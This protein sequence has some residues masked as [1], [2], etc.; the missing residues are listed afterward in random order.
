M[1]LHAWIRALPFVGA[2]LV[3]AGS[4]RI[5]FAQ[6]NGT[7][8]IA[9]ASAQPVTAAEAPAPKQRIAVATRT[10]PRGTVLSA[11]DF[12]L[13]DTTMRMSATRPHPTPVVAGWVPRRT[14]TAGEILREPAV[15]APS[16]VN[17]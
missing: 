11:G 17:A 3:G 12:E 4:S 2:L 16:V 8:V 15:E 1:R 6:S 13:R 7:R 10:L 14:I 5:A 9:Q